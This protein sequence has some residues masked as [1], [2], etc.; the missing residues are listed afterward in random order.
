[1]QTIE[2]GFQG[3][4]QLQPKVFEDARGYF[5]ESFNQKDMDF[6][7]LSHDWV[8]D[9]QSFSRYG[10]IRGLHFQKDPFAQAK[11]IRVLDGRILDVVVDI[12][13]GSPTFG[14]H[15]SLELSSENRT[16]LLVPKGFAHGFSVLSETATILY[17]CDNYYQAGHEGGIRYDDP[18]L[19][20]DWKLPATSVILSGKDQ[21]LPTLKELPKLFTYHG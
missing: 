4:V 21:L 19:G 20:I 15:F 8:Q 5:F 14:K 18:E 13:Q 12:R 1:M 16:Q 10:T 9:N 2:T 7:N 3:L 6:G 17:K 11:L